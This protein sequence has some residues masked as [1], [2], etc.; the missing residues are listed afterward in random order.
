MYI[1]KFRFNIKNEWSFQVLVS[2]NINLC[3]FLYQNLAYQVW[4]DDYGMS[5]TVKFIVIS[6]ICVMVTKFIL[7]L[8]LQ[9]YHCNN[10]NSPSQN[11]ATLSV[12]YIDTESRVVELSMV[13]LLIY[14]TGRSL[15]NTSILSIFVAID[16]NYNLRSILPAVRRER[17]IIVVLSWS[18]CT[19]IHLTQQFTMLF[20]YM[21]MWQLTHPS[22]IL[23]VYAEIFAMWKFSPISPTRVIGENFPSENFH[24]V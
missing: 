20:A 8:W 7:I 5:T 10:S 4:R 21:C 13:L 22:R 15:V 23:P 18:C 6:W 2:C 24:P 9:W 11:N 17:Y 19:L 12:S 1:Y 14:Q 3:T 16:Q